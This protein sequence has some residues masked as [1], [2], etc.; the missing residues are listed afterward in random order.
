MNNL[1][2]TDIKNYLE[3]KSI[4]VNSSCAIDDEFNGIATLKNA[5]EKHLTFYHNI[6]YKSLLETTKAKACLINEKN[7][8]MLNK[9]CIPI[10][11][12]DPYLA[13]ALLSNFIKPN[14]QSNGQISNTANIS[15]K[16]QIGTNVQINSNV[17]IKDNT[18]ISNDVVI[19]DN[20][21]I[22]P[23][24]KIESGSIVMSNCV[25]TDAFIGQNSTIQSGCIIGGQGF[26][27]AL[28]N[29][30]P[31]IHLGNVIIGNNVDIGSNTTID[32][33]TIDSTKIGNNVRIDNL[34]QI[35]HNVEIDDNTVIAAQTGISGSTIIGKN[36][37]IGGQ[38]G[39]VGHIEVGDNVTVASKSGVTKNI[40]NDSKI[41]GFP[42]QDINK[43]K[44]SIILLNKKN[45]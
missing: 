11:V 3:S 31:I 20:S 39:F 32:R 29:K 1:K 43:W 41:A 7:A 26:G 19:L 5:C 2:Y 27:F 36:C 23:N 6:K 28:K 18:L 22:G 10:I 16:S 35:A 21:T 45:K 30:T 8:E 15:K 25:I 9:T 33:G 40:P 17:V 37:I 42:A 4:K 34:V 44:K 14:L 13:Y 38:V 12:N 24:V